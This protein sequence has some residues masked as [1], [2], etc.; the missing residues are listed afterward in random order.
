LFLQFYVLV[1]KM[2][3]FFWNVD[4]CYFQTVSDLCEARI[5]LEN[6]ALEFLKWA[7]TANQLFP[8]N[9][10]NKLDTKQTSNWNCVE[11]N[12]TNHLQDCSWSFLL[13]WDASLCVLCVWRTNWRN[14]REKKVWNLLSFKEIFSFH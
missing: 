2:C 6:V 4:L 11:V 14:D 1:L 3:S 9:Q 7:D 5:H 8:V 10:F 12:H 13:C